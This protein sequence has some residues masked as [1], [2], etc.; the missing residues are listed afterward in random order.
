MSMALRTTVNPF[1]VPISSRPLWRTYSYYPQS[2][3]KCEHWEKLNKE[4]ANVVLTQIGDH[5]MSKTNSLSNGKMALSLTLLILNG[6]ALLPGIAIKNDEVNRFVG[7]TEVDLIQ[8]YGQPV[9]VRSLDEG[10]KTLVFE[11]RYEET[12]QEPARAYTNS[13][14]RMTSYQGGY[15]RIENHLERRVFT[16]DRN[17][18]V[19]KGQWKSY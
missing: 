17:G 19:I 3:G 2:N 13:R 10:G 7:K 12:I 4:C 14:G 6:C 5:E 1:S 15:T 18:T 11:W 8:K 9:D 16:T